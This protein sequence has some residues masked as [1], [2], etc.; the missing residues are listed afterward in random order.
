GELLADSG[1][2]GGKQKVP[3]EVLTIRTLSGALVAI[4]KSEVESVVRRRLVV[5]DYETLRRA[6]PDTASAHWD[7]AEWC[8]QKSLAKERENHLRKVVEFDPE[9]TAAHRA[10]GH[11][12]YQGQWA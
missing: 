10:L 4:G 9:H 5:E 11:V 2:A 7:L 3:A 1:P 6:A 8:R 12:K